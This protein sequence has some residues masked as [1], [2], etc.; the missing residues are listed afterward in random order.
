MAVTVFK[1]M[2]IGK[3]FA[4]RIKSMDNYLEKIIEYIIYQLDNKI[5]ANNF[6]DDWKKK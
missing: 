5:A 3:P 4:I 1:N 6:I 2:F